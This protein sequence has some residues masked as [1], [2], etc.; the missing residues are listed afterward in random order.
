MGAVDQVSA[1]AVFVK[2]GSE[3]TALPA[4]ATWFI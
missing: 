4:A 3:Y 1:S 2:A